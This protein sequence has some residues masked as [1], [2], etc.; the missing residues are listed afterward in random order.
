MRE[1]LVG[2]YQRDEQKCAG[3]RDEGDQREADAADGGAGAGAF[4]PPL[5]FPW[6]LP[7]PFV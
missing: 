3:Q 5:P 4:A 7:F 1:L 6:P 2:D